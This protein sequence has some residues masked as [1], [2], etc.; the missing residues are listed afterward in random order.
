[1]EPTCPVCRRAVQPGLHGIRLE[2]KHWVHAKCMNL[3][4]PDFVKCAACKGEVNM[5]IPQFDENEVDSING[6]DYVQKPLSDSFFTTFSRA[7]YKNKEPFKWIA[8]KSPIEWIIKEKGYG[9]Q[10]MIQSGVRFEDFL[11]AGYTWDELKA[12]RDFGDAKRRERAKEALFALKCNA[13]QLRD[14]PH[15]VGSLVKELDISGRNL[16]ELYGLYFKEKSAQP[17]MVA[18]GQNTK[19]WTASHLVNLGFK[20]K[21]LY[22][23]GLEYIEQYAD[24][25]PTD[26]DE[27]AMEVKDEDVNNLPSLTEIERERRRL[28]ETKVMDHVDSEDEEI[29]P[30]KRNY[31]ERFPTIEIKPVKQLHGLRSKNRSGN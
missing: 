23:A 22:G 27:V 9:I 17:L 16:V 20:M 21:D 6:R 19:P 30:Q 8:E 10:K 4:E 7:Y 13:E 28:M 3:K 25:K 29:I 24:L 14:Y 2:C 26:A 18:G 11:N 5:N 31:I 15:L 12:F 1:M